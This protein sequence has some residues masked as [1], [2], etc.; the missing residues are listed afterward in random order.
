MRSI[1]G[2]CKANYGSYC[3]ILST[4]NF[5]GLILIPVSM[6]F[7]ILLSISMLM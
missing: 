7:D 5:C 2:K 3:L 1:D 6:K 4:L